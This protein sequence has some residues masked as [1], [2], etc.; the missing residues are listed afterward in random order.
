ML[1]VAFI[2][3][4]LSCGILAWRRRNRNKDE[5]PTIPGALPLIGHIYL[6][7]GIDP[8]QLWNTVKKEVYRTMN[9]GGVT[10][11]NIGLRKVYFVTDPDDCLK[12]ANTCLQKDDF[13][14]FAK[15]WVGDG[16]VTADLQTWKVHR[17]LLTPAFNQFVL[18]GFIDVLN[19]QAHRLVKNL[20]VEVD[21][22][23]FDHFTYILPNGLETTC[24]TVMEVD[25]SDGGLL[26]SE[27]VHATKNM[28]NSMVERLVNP[29]LYS[30][31]VFNWSSLKRKQDEYVKILH[32]MSNTV[33]KKRKAEY[34][35]NKL[36]KGTEYTTKGPKFR[37]FMELLLE[38]TIEK[39]VFSDREIREHVDTMLFAGH[40]TTS[41]SL[42]YTMLLVGSYPEVQQ[43]IFEELHDVFGDDD[44]DVT[45]Q[46]LSRLVYLEAVLNES[47]RIY[48]IAPVMARKLDQDIKLRNCTLLKN[49]TCFLWAYGVH[50]HPMWGPDAEE[51]KPERWLDPATLPK[52][53]TAFAGFGKTY[54]MM[55]MK[56]TLAHVFRRYRVFGN[57]LLMVTKF[58]VMLKPVSGHHIAIEIR[59][60]SVKNET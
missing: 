54:A 2:L 30:D 49:R 46:D 28:L 48:P 39:G 5:P 1:A 7:L 19:R 34:L 43:K 50:R 52:C 26:N 22:G 24:L 27:Y 41:T 18:D 17:K 59:K 58:E 60:K 8:Q 13:Y 37:S 10:S 11:G 6:F 3:V 25:F 51:F 47:L 56:I 14:K 21:K 40:D 9:A 38:L 12:I 33:L 36:H 15:P 31:A 4:L 20:E 23:P 44:R 16:L 53:P 57:H 29:W 32:N 42:M 45:K 55:S 35:N